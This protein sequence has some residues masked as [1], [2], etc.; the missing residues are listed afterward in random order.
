[1]SMTTNHIEPTEAYGLVGNVGQLVTVGYH[2]EMLHHNPE[3]GESVIPVTITD[4]RWLTREAFEAEYRAAARVCGAPCWFKT[5]DGFTYLGVWWQGMYRGYRLNIVSEEIFP[6]P[7][8][9][10]LSVMPIHPP[11]SPSE[12]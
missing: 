12:E 10:V 8:G 6:A 7:E 4:A 1:M 11:Q 9:V 3:K 5:E 2:K